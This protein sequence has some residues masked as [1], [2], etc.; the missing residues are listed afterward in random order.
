MHFDVLVQVRKKKKKKKK[1]K[2][3]RKLSRFKDIKIAFI[4]PLLLNI[5][6]EFITKT[7]LYTSDPLKS[8]FI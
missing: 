1:K 7:C 4:D 5:E 3:T 6:Q 2:N 8:T